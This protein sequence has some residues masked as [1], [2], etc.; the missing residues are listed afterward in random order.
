MI[1]ELGHALGIASLMESDE[2]VEAST[3]DE[4]V[5]MRAGVGYVFTGDIATKVYNDF[6]YT[7]TISQYIPMD[8]A[9]EQVKSHFGIVNGL[10]TH[11]TFR[12]YGGF[13]EV[14]L[15]ALNDMGYN[16]T[17]GD[18]FGR[19][20]YTSNNNDD[21]SA[22]IINNVGFNKD[23][24]YGLG[25]HVFG[26]NNHVTQAA[27]ISANGLAGAGIRSDGAENTIIV[28]DGVTI[29]ANG[30]YGVGVLF[31]YGHDSVL[32]NQGTIRAM[33]ENETGD[34][35][36]FDI[37]R[38]AVG[39]GSIFYEQSSY[40]DAPISG[41][42]EW[43]LAEQL[44]SGALVKTFDL[45]GTL[46]ATRN[47]IYISPNAH[48][49]TINIR[50]G[51]QISGDIVSDY[52]DLGRDTDRTTKI[53]LGL[54]ADSNNVDSDFRITLNDRI[55]GYGA[56]STKTDPFAINRP[57]GYDGGGLY[58]G[59]GRLDLTLA[60]G[61]TTLGAGAEVKV[62]SFNLNTGADLEILGANGKTLTTIASNNFNLAEG[63]TVT[64]DL[65]V[66]SFLPGPN[67][68]HLQ[69]L[70]Q[71]G[72]FINNSTVV[73]RTYEEGVIL[74]IYGYDNYTLGWDPTKH[75]VRLIGIDQNK[76][77]RVLAGDYA[78]TATTAMLITHKGWD[79]VAR[80]SR[81]G[82][83]QLARGDHPLLGGQT[84]PTTGRLWFGPFYSTTDQKGGG[85]RAGYDLKTYGAAL[86]YDWNFDQGL[87]GLAFSASRPD[88][89][90]AG[91]EIEATTLSVMAYGGL[92]L[93]GRLELGLQ[94]G[95]DW[96]DYSQVRKI[97]GSRYTADYEGGTY[98][99]GVSLGRT[100]ELGDGWDVRPAISHEYFSLNVD[101]YHESD[102]LHSIALNSDRQN[103]HRTKVGAEATWR[104]DP[105]GW[106]V[107]GSLGWSYLSGD[108][109]SQA[110]GFM[111]ADPGAGPFL[112]Y[113]DKMDK[114]SADVGLSLAL[115]VDLNWSVE[116]NYD[117]NVGSNITTHSGELKAV[118]VF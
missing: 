58:V 23:S 98:R 91:T 72:D 89:S 16:I 50:T 54:A 49:D 83:Q 55:I 44:L 86:G 14:E 114:N 57:G 17:L 74:G 11:R 41:Y 117:A 108:L 65:G 43:E 31:A 4:M 102:G 62:N 68:V 25:L 26:G 93:P 76:R 67:V 60:G 27:D 35:V 32:V 15:A 47:A 88:Y 56:G 70:D 34:A 63:S 19:S 66:D 2:T 80:Q 110:K 18:F 30:K 64:I 90:G 69:Q 24:S 12:N 99:A 115:P 40:Y 92:L 39:D 78:L 96:T 112:A 79:E 81:R 3:F 52:D 75:Y 116:A 10:M 36:R 104:N 42:D 101:T 95:Y 82:L 8:N 84:M 38:N 87:I 94:G 77:Y 46:E 28:G 107:S 109:N 105:V 103:I 97:W 100:F 9:S 53:I 59:R 48:V 22:S 111:R 71:Y 73:S 7:G 45:T 21:D 1:H 106:K 113:G 37:G 6:P 20:I 5:K 61:I 51:A 118:L 13:M 85:E 29:E 33:G